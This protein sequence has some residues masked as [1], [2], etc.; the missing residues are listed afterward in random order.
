MEGRE[1]GMKTKGNLAYSLII[2][3]VI[4]LLLNYSH[5][6]VYIFWFVFL[7][8]RSIN[9]LLAFRALVVGL[10]NGTYGVPA[11]YHTDPT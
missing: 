9:L 5:Y 11:G 8:K 4:M 1:G 3:P 10:F 6:S 7:L 2:S